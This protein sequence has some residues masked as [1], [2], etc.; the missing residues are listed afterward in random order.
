MRLIFRPEFYIDSVNIGI[1]PS[2]KSPVETLI[3]VTN[4]L[5]EQVLI[6][7]MTVVTKGKSMMLVPLDGFNSFVPAKVD[8][9]PVTILRIY[10][11]IGDDQWVK[12]S[13][14]MSYSGIEK[15][16]RKA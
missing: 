14:R 3:Y 1:I 16:V 7:D 6:H 11:T 13:I 4:R 10:P 9:Y 12:S 8:H 5:N 15:E 2:K